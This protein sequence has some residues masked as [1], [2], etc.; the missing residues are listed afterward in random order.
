MFFAVITCNGQQKSYS[1]LHIDKESRSWGLNLKDS[2]KS[3]RFFYTKY[4]EG[5]NPTDKSRIYY[6]NDVRNNFYYEFDKKGNILSQMMFL[7]DSINQPIISD[8]VHKFFY[9]VKDIE[10]KSKYVI[11]KKQVYPAYIDNLVKLYHHEYF[12]LKSY[13]APELNQTFF[14]YTFEDGK[15]KEERRYYA[16]LYNNKLVDRPKESDL[17]IMQI[18]YYDTRGN[19][20]KQQIFPGAVGKRVGS[21]S[22]L[23]TE[24]N[25]CNDSNLSYEYDNMDR[26]IKVKLT[27][28]KT[29]IASEEY[30]YHPSKNYITKLKRFINEP[31]FSSY[32][33][34]NMIADYNEYGDITHMHFVVVGDTTPPRKKIGLE[35]VDRYYDYDYD[36]HNNWIKCRMYLMGDKD[37]PTV[38][39]ERIIEYYNE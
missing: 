13:S 11:N 29:L 28:C 26:V 18:Y 15:I 14:D 16:S 33:S 3:V 31:M 37:E 10:L 1:G 5:L 35:P 2:V 20:I 38:T 12:K 21:L 30:I 17:D 23:E 32:P 22:I 4:K 27:S 7:K 8:S 6:S 39:A 36:R 34:R 19:L 9:D 25:F 24:I